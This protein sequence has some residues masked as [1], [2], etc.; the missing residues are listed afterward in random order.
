M[1]KTLFAH[2]GESEEPVTTGDRLSRCGG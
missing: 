2:T 1:P